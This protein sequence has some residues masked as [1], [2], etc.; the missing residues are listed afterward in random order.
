MPQKK[1][2]PPLPE[3][4]PPTADLSI[5][6]LELIAEDGEE[7]ALVLPLGGLNPESASQPIRNRVALPP[8]ARSVKVRAFTTCRYASVSIFRWDD[9]APREQMRAIDMVHRTVRCPNAPD[10]STSE[11]ASAVFM[12]AV[13]RGLLSRRREGTPVP[14]VKR[15]ANSMMQVAGFAREAK[16]RWTRVTNMHRPAPP[17]PKGKGKGKNSTSDDATKSLAVPMM[18]IRDASPDAIRD[19][20]ES[21]SLEFKTFLR[22]NWLAVHAR[23]SSLEEEAGIENEE[24]GLCDQTTFEA[25][26]YGLGLPKDADHDLDFPL[27]YTAI[28]LHPSI[29]DAR[30][31]FHELP[32]YQIP[33]KWD[34]QRDHSCLLSLTGATKRLP[35][36]SQT[37]ADGKGKG[38]GNKAKPQKSSETAE[39]SKSLEQREEEAQLALLP[40]E[41]VVYFRVCVIGKDFSCCIYQLE[42]V[43]APDAWPLVPSLPPSLAS[44]VDTVVIGYYGAKGTIDIERF[45]ACC[46][47]LRIAS[48]PVARMAFQG[49]SRERPDTLLSVQSAWEAIFFCFVRQAG[50]Q[51]LVQRPPHQ[52]IYSPD[53]I[54]A[55]ATP[56]LA[57]VQYNLSAA[58]Y[59]GSGHFKMT[60]E[61]TAAQSA[62]E[63]KDLNEE[64]K[65]FEITRAWWLDD[66]ED[67]AHE[68]LT[69]QAENEAAEEEQE[70]E[71]E[72]EEQIEDVGTNAIASAESVAVEEGE[73]GD[74]CTSLSKASNEIHSSSMTNLTAG[75]NLLETAR[76]DDRSQST[77]ALRP[78]AIQK[79]PESP[80]FTRTAPMHA[81][82]VWP[83]TPARDTPQSTGALE[84]RRLYRPNSSNPALA[85]SGTV[86]SPT[87]TSPPSSTLTE[88]PRT[89]RQPPPPPG[90]LAYR[91]LTTAQLLSEEERWAQQAFPR[92]PLE[93]PEASPPKI[94]ARLLARRKPP[95]L[96]ASILTSKSSGEQAVWLK[97]YQD[98]LSM[99]WREQRL[100]YRPPPQMPGA[101][102]SSLVGPSPIGIAK[103]PSVPAQVWRRAPFSSKLLAMH[104]QQSLTL[105]HAVTATAQPVFPPSGSLL[106]RLHAPKPPATSTAGKVKAPKKAGKKKK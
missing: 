2:P 62:T 3:A 52:L 53:K 77:E 78:S 82:L 55:S 39:G 102:A 10:A 101:K 26:L 20:M 83:S 80:R 57:L 61:R 47:T 51:P 1:S 50:A 8:S 17:P 75:V 29:P 46:T 15:V 65:P 31:K 33:L 81:K 91:S 18:E 25:V 105:P 103:I 36:Q 38:G 58:S 48:A 90:A 72:E 16:E 86:A 71:G 23:L 97:A 35:P 40:P 88:I 13:V 67:I 73:V 41:T 87:P 59:L 68:V 37:K 9:Y 56:C 93:S 94:D 30:I 49:V 27:F 89:H 34:L 64:P 24:R 100:A 43:L 14:R 45:V 5:A 21:V 12:Q 28:G 32:R 6:K 66:K 44:F 76:Q 42:I 92:A 11:V 4:P 22:A 85:P 70:E 96:S 74:S 84:R 95:S 104:A 60:N 54:L 19:P 69:R 79:E 63:L 7:E 99:A 106:A 98:H